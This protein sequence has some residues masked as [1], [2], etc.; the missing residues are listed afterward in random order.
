MI[1]SDE[2]LVQTWLR[3][4]DIGP[5][6]FTEI[7]PINIYNNWCNQ[8]DIDSHIEAIPENNAE[9]YHEQCVN[10]WHMPEEYKTLDL[11]D[12][13]YTKVCQELQMAK[14]DFVS[15]SSKWI[16][17]EQELTEYKKR[18][19]MPVLQFLIFLTDV[20][21]ENNI[22]LGVGRG[23]SVASYILYLIGIHKVD[24]IKYELDIKEF[25]K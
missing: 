11:I 5:A 6:V 9:D 23:S 25:L 2:S 22:V 24:S 1:L 7:D 14:S 13:L 4:E 3:D 15:N 19:M 16:R 12:H 20:C 18:G 21:Q 8:F 17:V 10:T